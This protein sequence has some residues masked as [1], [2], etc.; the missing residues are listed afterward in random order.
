MLH[1]TSAAPSVTGSLVE[2]RYLALF[3]PRWATDC[4]K[5]RDPAL[6]ASR[7][8]LALYEKQ[9]SALRLVAVDGCAHDKGLAPRQSL[10]DAKARVPELDAREIDR[11]LI[12]AIFADFADWHSY[13]SP[14]VSI[15]TD[16]AAF[17]DLVLDI[18]GVSHLFGGEERMLK[19]VCGRLEALG[20]SV[21]GA[22]APNV[23]AA[24]ALAH[25]APGQ[26]VGGNVAG[27]LAHLPVA[28][29][30]LEESQIVDLMELGLKRI[31][32][33]YGRDR[34]AL[35]AR[36]GVSLLLRLDQMLGHIE[37]RI[38]PRLP[39]PERYSERRFADPIGLIDDVLMAVEDVSVRLTA[40][41]EAEGL[42]AQS[43][44]LFLYRVDHRLMTL[45]VNA[46]RA[47][48][49]VGHIVRLFG[50]RAERLSN[51][52][53]AGFGIDMVRL[54]ATTVSPLDPAQIGAFETRDGAADIDRL[55]DRMMSRLGGEAVL[56]IAFVNTH[57]PERAAQLRPVMDY[58]P[59]TPE[60]A[61]DADLERPLRLLP[62]PERIEVT[63][64]VPDG[65]P[66]SMIW[67]RI[68]YRFAKASGPERI[69]AEWWHPE[70]S[71]S[72][73][74]M[75]PPD[76]LKPE[77]GPK[78]LIVRHDIASRDYYV[79]EDD[80]GRRFWLFREDLYAHS[81]KP[82]WFMHGFFS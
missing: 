4:L 73:V 30:R 10:S 46:A 27:V 64:D 65:P 41:L 37:E 25:F 23:G 67:R 14:I 9:N 8:P 38:K 47:T 50:N 12:E 42:G 34:K 44:Q 18:T 26:V 68:S 79:A 6:G 70:F 74:E 56:R 5:R 40:Q 29:M 60:A 52:F 7:R 59:P 22:I 39:I 69:A 1:R 36:F 13:A 20:F 80:G 78:A 3:L 62:N 17:G 35:Q 24:W 31:G 81:P 72:H 49:D 11:Q 33:L 58:R 63:A 15:L 61:P 66:A 77:K 16:A 53:D 45:T 2:R 71:L 82:A 28:A 75:L 48:R 51:E 43:F 32:Q 55:Y 21:T 54:A 57:I 76:P 19:V